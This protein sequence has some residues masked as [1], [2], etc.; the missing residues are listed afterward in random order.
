MI[1]EISTR[2]VPFSP[3][4]GSHDSTTSSSVVMWWYPTPALELPNFIWGSC[5][6]KTTFCMRINMAY[7]EVIH[8]RRN[9]FQVLS[10]AS[11]KA[12]VSELARLF[13]AYVYTPSLECIAL[14]TTT[15]I[16]DTPPKAKSH[17]QKQGLC[18]AS[19]TMHG[20]M[21]GW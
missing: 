15:V 6:A 8:W 4:T 7:K 20:Y 13:Q 9:I 1:T 12:F 19:S 18:H 10:G 2:E 11:G 21:A 16:A 14:K 17:K 5:S 3:V